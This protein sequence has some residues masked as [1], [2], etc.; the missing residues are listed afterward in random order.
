MS[1]RP[2]RGV[3]SQNSMSLAASPLTQLLCLGATVMSSVGDLEDVL[4]DTRSDQ[5]LPIRMSLAV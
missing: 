5:K 4:L 3:S 1:S 2:K